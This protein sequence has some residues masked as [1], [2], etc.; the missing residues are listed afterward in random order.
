[1]TSDKT[2]PSPRPSTRERVLDAAERL[3]ASGHAGFSM[4]DLA[5]EASLSFATPFN[6]FG[7]KGAIMLALSARRIDAMRERLNH[8][9]SA[10]TAAASVLAAV[11]IAASVMLEAPSVNRVV[12]G[13]IGSPSDTPGAVSSRS[14]DLWSLALGE[15]AGLADATRDLALATLPDPLALAFRGALSF[16]TAGEYDDRALRRS[17]RSA[18]AA[19]L[20]GFVRADERRTLLATM[21]DGHRP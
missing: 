7:S 8:A 10:G 17:A 2:S 4:R 20:F 9:P 1:M 13:S 5:S 21:A 15:G 12:M 19:C 18:A 6:Q 3:L 11:D 14:R 16:W